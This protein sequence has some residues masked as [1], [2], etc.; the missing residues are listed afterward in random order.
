MLRAD[1]QDFKV[2]LLTGDLD[3]TG[4]RLNLSSDVAGIAQG[5]YIRVKTIK[6]ELFYNQEFG[7]PYFKVEGI[8]DEL[9]ALLGQKLDLGQFEAALRTVLEASPGVIQVLALSVSENRRTRKVSS[10]WQL[11]TAF[12]DTPVA[13]LVH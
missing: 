12:G 9:D 4:G 5:A 1:K 11:R 7:V 6:G 10:R 2:D 8:V 13:Q 3:V